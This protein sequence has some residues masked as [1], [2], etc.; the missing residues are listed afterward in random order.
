MLD[1]HYA[2]EINIADYW[3]VGDSRTITLGY[4]VSSTNT[5][6]AAEQE[7]DFVIIG[8][9]H[10]DLETTINETTKAAITLQSSNIVNRGIINS[11]SGYDISMFD[12]GFTK[13]N[14]H[15]YL[16]KVY[17]ALP[18]E[19]KDLIK[20]VN[21]K[22]N[23]YSYSDYSYK[24]KQRTDAYT[25]FL[26][27]QY[28]VFGVNNLDESVYGTLDPDGEQYGYMKTIS[29]RCKELSSVISTGSIN[30]STWA[31]RTFYLTT[32]NGTNVISVLR[33]TGEYTVMTV[34]N[35]GNGIA[36]AFCL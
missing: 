35:S 36:P 16:D 14:M 10:D 5:P 28:E 30:Y 22:G 34:T 27:S 25:V 23:A 13:S 18:T 20:P 17:N 7:V 9:N 6:A 32:S 26:L 19:I 12:G 2:G 21:K 1:A 8:I 3:S 29:N 4:L 15:S 31:T 33:D 24:R 11:L